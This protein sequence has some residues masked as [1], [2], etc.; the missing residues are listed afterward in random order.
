MRNPSLLV[1][2][3]LG[4]NAILNAALLVLFTVSQVMNI[5]VCSQNLGMRRLFRSVIGQFEVGGQGRLALSGIGARAPNCSVNRARELPRIVPLRLR[6]L[7]DVEARRGEVVQIWPTLRL[8]A[9][10]R[11][12]LCTWWIL[13]RHSFYSS[14]LSLA[15]VLKIVRW[16]THTC[17]LQ[18][19]VLE[20]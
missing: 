16:F 5:V 14:G 15:G 9:M 3:V 2:V 12:R 18:A 20:I 4:L 10:M 11:R 6:C 19:T 7:L 13:R 8:H 17:N 1:S